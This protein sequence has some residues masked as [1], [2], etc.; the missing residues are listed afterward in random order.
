MPQVN[1]TE[2]YVSLEALA[3]NTTEVVQQT[4]TALQFT[5]L[6]DGAVHWIAT[7]STK[8]RLAHN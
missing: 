3:D 8:T 1:A 6:D 4:T 2:L 5:A 7:I